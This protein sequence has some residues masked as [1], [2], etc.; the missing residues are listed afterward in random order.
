MN[1][2]PP[3]NIDIEKHILGSILIDKQ[4]DIHKLVEED[5]YNNTCRLIFNTISNLYICKKNIDVITVSDLLKN[6]IDNSLKMIIS[7]TD[8]IT[9]TA[10][11]NSM[12]EKLKTYTL[13]RQ[14]IKKSL[15]LNEL[16][17]SNEQDAIELKNEAMAIMDLKIYNESNEDEGIIDV[18][19]NISADIKKRIEQKEDDKLFTGFADLDKVLAGFHAEEL[20]ILAARPGV[21]K[22]AFALQLMIN[23]AE[24]NN[25]CYFVSREMSKMQ[26]GKRLL[27]N[28]SGVEGNKLR[29]CKNLNDDDF[30]KLKKGKEILGWM[31]LRLDDRTAT[32]QEIR[33][34]CREL[35]NK[36]ELDILIVDYLQLLKANGKF[37]SRREEIEYIS[38]SLKEL[39]ME[40]CI[41]VI[42]LSQLSRSNV[43]TDREP[44]L[45]DLRES[46]SLEQ[47]AD[48]VIFLHQEK[49]E[50]GSDKNE[51]KILI[52][53][54]R[55]G[56]TGF[57]RFAY[58]KEVLRFYSTSN[59]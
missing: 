1:N 50:D 36:G 29:L 37:G 30:K 51:I 21:G 8:L 42:A 49:F 59:M 23:L 47:D 10:D 14:I 11:F 55:N 6:S 28:V 9:T 17:H 13:K 39:S 5:F 25:Y 54:Q 32:V 27:A 43:S 18:I 3:N 48:N 35:Y 44:E 52:K 4:N 31:K 2:A 24:K 19:N 53:K 16:V 46:G 12:L 40:F 45:H 58:K 41:P 33:S 38:R 20:T 15:K 56:G 57:V 26:L 34:K 7:L 22:T